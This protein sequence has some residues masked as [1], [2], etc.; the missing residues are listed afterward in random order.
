MAFFSN[1]PSLFVYERIK[2]LKTPLIICTDN[3]TKEQT[4]FYSAQEYEQARNK[5]KP[6]NFRYIKG[7]GSL[8]V[9]EYRRAVREP[10]YD[11]VKLDKNYK[12]I[13]EVLYG[14][15]TNLRKEWMSSGNIINED[16][17]E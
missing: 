7:L 11:V 17:D 14:D 3:K 10:V 2:F 12:E 8:E 6:H 9:D 15:D 1:W 5:L 4:W 16:E 13:F